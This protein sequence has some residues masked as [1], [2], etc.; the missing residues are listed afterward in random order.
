[1]SEHN[2]FLGPHDAPPPTE[3]QRDSRL[4]LELRQIAGAAAVA[5]SPVPHQQIIRRGTRRRRRRVVLTAAAAIL[6]VT[7][8]ITAAAALRNHPTGPAVPAPPPSPSSPPA[9][10]TS[11]STVFPSRLPI[12]AE[13]DSEGAP[14]PPRT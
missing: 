7:T 8:V 5:V 12:G 10:S 11:L 6:C 4:R 3:G 1:M 14:W 2:P 13:D 9:P